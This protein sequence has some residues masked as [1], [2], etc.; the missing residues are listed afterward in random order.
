MKKTILS[1]GLLCSLFMYSCKKGDT[2][3]AGAT[4]PAG[5]AGPAGSPNVIYSAWFTPTTYVKD[6]VFN[7]WRFTYLK[8]V[9]EITQPILDSGTILVYGKLEG[10]NSAIWPTGQVSVMPI[11]V[12]Y[13]FSSGGITYTDTWSALFTPG[14]IR[15]VFINDANYYTS[16]S[17]AH[18][19][20]YIIIPGGVKSASSSSTTHK[21]SGQTETNAVG[22][23]QSHAAPDF[24][25]MSY[26][27]VC[28]YFKI[29]A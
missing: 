28:D 18:Q 17:N 10:Y 29:P 21:V 13:K 24:K 16:I 26:A 7:L 22:S 23:T 27:D 3:P 15:V 12:Q 5:P 19:F 14:Q 8:A 20:R 11:S 9:A 2:G 25:S 6:T 1:L 4:G